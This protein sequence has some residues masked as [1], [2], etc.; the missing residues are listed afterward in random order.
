MRG[1]RG[2][3]EYTQYSSMFFE[4][5]FQKNQ[6]GVSPVPREQ[7]I[8]LFQQFFNEMKIRV[9]EEGLNDFYNRMCHSGP[10]KR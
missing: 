1:A 5:V 4:D 10:K 2:A 6:Q 3:F 8:I 7:A 9:G